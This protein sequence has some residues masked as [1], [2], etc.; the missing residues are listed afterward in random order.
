MKS[1]SL[2]CGIALGDTKLPKSITSKPTDNMD[3]M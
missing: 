1:V 3:C 2:I